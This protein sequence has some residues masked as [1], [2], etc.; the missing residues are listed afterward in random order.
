MS[1]FNFKVFSI[2]ALLFFTFSFVQNFFFWDISS[3]CFIKILPSLN[4]SNSKIREALTVLK[5]ASPD[6]LKEVCKRVS[7]IDP[8]V[9]CGGFEG[10]CFEKIS[11]R[12]S[13]D[14]SSY[15]IA[16][17]AQVIVHE[18][19]HVRQGDEKRPFSEPECHQAG[20]QVLN[21]LVMYK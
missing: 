21:D 18:A 10:G 5:N 6:N 19:C 15:S 14:T 20:Y 12:I 11:K 16:T 13:V 3:G 1:F 17:V 4:L 7:T 9:S 2:I 8:N